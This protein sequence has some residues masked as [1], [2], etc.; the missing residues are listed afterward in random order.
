M[1]SAQVAD[2]CGGANCLLNHVDAGDLP[3]Q[4]GF[5]LWKCRRFTTNGRRAKS[6]VSRDALEMLL[7]G[8]ITMV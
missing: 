7:A 1:S 5:R 4:H 2:V 6:I 8:N 3:A